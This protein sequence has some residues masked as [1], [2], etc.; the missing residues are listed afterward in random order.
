MPRFRAHFVDAN[1][2]SR[3]LTL[4]AVD[5]ASVVRHVEVQCRSHVLAV[6][7]AS[8]AGRPP[9]RLKVR[10]QILLAAMDSLELMLMSGVRVNAAARTLADC[11]PPGPSRRLW[12]EVVRG[13]EGTGSFAEAI[14][15]FSRVFNAS[16]VGVVA[17]H[18][19]AGRLPEG[20]HNARDYLGQMQE[21]RRESLRGVAYPALVCAAGLASSVV[22]CT[23]TLPRFSK[24]LRDI[25]VAK[26]NGLTG[27][28]FGLSDVVVRHP[29]WAAATP[30]L[31]AALIWVAFRPRFRPLVDR[32]VLRLPLV[33]RAV[34]ALSMAR[35][36]ITY[37]ALSESGVRVV[38]ALEHCAV[39]AGN[40]VYAQG[41]RRVVSAVRENAS[42]GSAFEGAGV[43]APEIVLAIKSGEGALPR[44]FGRLADYYT[45]EAR[46]RVVLALRMVE[47][48]MLVVVLAWVFGVALA[49]VL[50]VVEVINEIH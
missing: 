26:S 15:P 25:G 32:L 36:C 7:R 34:E 1:G 9:G 24:M 2:R 29:V 49:V 6:E 47:P 21:V 39:A 41:I 10:G 43:F 28:F 50:P 14:R 22:L 23:F 19:A 46:H 8:G 37:K 3:R 18:E 20:I 17:A 4:D 13:I 30:C 16:I 45:S 11:S 42:I 12:T 48:V 38:E 27:F 35:I 40:S 31:P 44:V 5:A 33:H